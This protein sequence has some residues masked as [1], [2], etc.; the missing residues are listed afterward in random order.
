MKRAL[1]MVLTLG[2]CALAVPTHDVAIADPVPD[3]FVL[4]AVA[5]IEAC[6]GRSC[7][8]GGW[9]VWYA[10]FEGDDHRFACAEASQCGPLPE[11]CNDPDDCPC[12]CRGYTRFTTMQVVVTADLGALKHE[13]IH[14]CFD[15]ADHDGSEWE[16][17]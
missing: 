5:E 11:G 8:L 6:T 1:A 10:A 17:Q 15:I 4:E 14:A 16:C 7:D 13:L 12:R 3:P 2:A 9:S